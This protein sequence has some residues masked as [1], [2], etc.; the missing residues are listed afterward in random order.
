M[1]IYKFNT[2]IVCPIDGRPCA[3]AVRIESR[4]MI[5]TEKIEKADQKLRKKKWAQEQ[6]TKRLARALGTRVVTEGQ[7]GEFLIISEHG[8]V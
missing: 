5:W 2:S 3:Y 6:Y 1:N 8:V 4:E 7:H